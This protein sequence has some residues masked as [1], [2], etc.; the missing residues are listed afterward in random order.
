MVWYSIVI[1]MA[2]SEPFLFL[3]KN[4]IMNELVKFSLEFK[5]V[6]TQIN[7]LV[8]CLLDVSAVI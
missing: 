2:L 6:D 4:K 5:T 3:Q 1:G 8:Y 7:S